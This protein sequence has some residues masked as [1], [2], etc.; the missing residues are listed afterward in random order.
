[1]SPC[2]EPIPFTFQAPL[3]SWLSLFAD[4]P[5][6]ELNGASGQHAEEGPNTTSRPKPAQPRRLPPPADGASQRLPQEPPALL[7]LL[8]PQLRG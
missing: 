4:L 7:L 1:M 5:S 3:P 2:A 6:P 8:C